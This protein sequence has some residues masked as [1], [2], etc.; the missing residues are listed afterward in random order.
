MKDSGTFIDG[1]L[2]KTEYAYQTIRDMLVGGQLKPGDAVSI[3]T[4]REKLDIG[5]TPAREALKRLSGENALVVGANRV[6]YVPKLG[7]EQFNEIRNLRCLL[8]GEAASVGAKFAAEQDLIVFRDIYHRMNETIAESDVSK[9]LQCNWQFHQ[10]IYK[11]GNSPLLLS[12]IEALWMRA[13]PYVSI[14]TIN[15]DHLKASMLHHQSILHALEERD[16]LATRSAIVADIAAASVDILKSLKADE[17]AASS[18]RRRRGQ[19]S[20]RRKTAG[21]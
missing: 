8:E 12:M 3:N 19:A 15:Q 5:A 2:S 4:L 14:A 11:M 16:S 20:L 9:Y 17:K 18:G 21:S 7:Y 6:L 10:A 1:S 13:G